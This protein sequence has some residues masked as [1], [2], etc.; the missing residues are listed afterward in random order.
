[1]H[2]RQV[3]P[4][5][6]AARALRA[7]TVSE[8]PSCG[9]SSSKNSK[10]CTYSLRGLCLSASPSRTSTFLCFSQVSFLWAGTFLGAAVGKNTPMASF[11]ALGTTNEAHAAPHGMCV[12][13]HPALFIQSLPFSLPC[14]PHEDGNTL[15][16][17]II[18]VR[19]VVSM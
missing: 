6:G 19:I 7:G 9:S 18:V 4:C 5:R 16:F 12:W 14:N 17:T 10:P 2:P 15:F 3:G 1:M 13:H 8:E 11:L